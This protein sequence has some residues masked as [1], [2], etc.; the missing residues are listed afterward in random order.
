MVFT[1]VLPR[2]ASL[3]L[4]IA[5]VW[6]ITALS[7]VDW[8]ICSINAGGYPYVI[9]SANPYRQCIWQLG[10]RRPNVL[11]GEIPNPVPNGT[12]VCSQFSQNDAI[13]PNPVIS[14]SA[15]TTCAAA[16]VLAVLCTTV[17]L[18]V[19]SLGS[20]IENWNQGRKPVI[21]ACFSVLAAMWGLIAMATWS[22]Q[23]QLQL[24]QQINQLGRDYRYFEPRCE[25][26][27]PFILLICAWPLCVFAAMAGFSIG[28]FKN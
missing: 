9:V 4:L 12:L 22:D 16:G 1:G 23:I 3:C 13:W 7:L 19:H 26:G 17:A 18:V 28:H 25:Q 24:Y 6:Y 21:G 2:T 20:V 14:D 8:Q 11:A 15:Y 27:I 10:T 5:W